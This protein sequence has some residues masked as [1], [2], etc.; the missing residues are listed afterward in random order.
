MGAVKKVRGL[1]H[2]PYEDRLQELSLFSLEKRHMGGVLIS[3]CIY[4]KGWCQEEPDSPMVPN[5]K[6][7]GNGH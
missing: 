3:A 6:T 2:P 1:E 4:L 5:I 7:R